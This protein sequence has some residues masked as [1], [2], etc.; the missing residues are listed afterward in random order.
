MLDYGVN[1]GIL[2]VFE[3][4]GSRFLYVEVVDMMTVRSL[5]EFYI[6]EDYREN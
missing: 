5:V 4:V 1:Q 6:S 2:A 3:V